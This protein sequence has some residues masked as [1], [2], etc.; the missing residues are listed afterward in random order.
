[1]NSAAVLFALILLVGAICLFLIARSLRRSTGLPTGRV[2]YSDTSAWVR[3]DQVLYSKQHRIA[4]KPDYLVR[5]GDNII[6]VEVK[7]SVAPPAPRPGHIMQ[8][9]AYCLLV[10][11]TQLIRPAYGIIQY[12]DRQFAIDYTDE[13]RDELMHTAVCMRSDAE[14]SDGPQRSHTDAGRCASCGL[15]HEC[16][17]QMN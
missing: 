8:L 6:P 13:L 15:R 5:D 12:A 1:M 9:A 14:L 7:S 2:I 4:G 3:N 11:E 10:E 16:N 17:Q